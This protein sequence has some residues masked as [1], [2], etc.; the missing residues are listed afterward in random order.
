MPQLKSS[1]DKSHAMGILDYRPWID[2]LQIAISFALAHQLTHQSAPVPYDLA[3]AYVLTFVAINI[4][5]GNYRSYWRYTGLHDAI[6][7][8]LASVAVGVSSIAASIFLDGIN[9]KVAFVATILSILGMV[10]VRV[11]RRLHH[12]KSLKKKSAGKPTLVIGTNSNM[13]SFL[14]LCRRDNGKP[15]HPTGIVA[16]SEHMLGRRLHHV[17]VV[18]TMSDIRDAIIRSGA[19][20]VVAS[21]ANLEAKELQEVMQASHDCGVKLLLR[22]EG[23]TDSVEGI[24][25]VNL[26]DLLPRRHI[27]VDLNGVYKSLNDKI[28][29]VTGG[30]GSIGSELCR[31]IARSNFSKLIVMDHSEFNLFQIGQELA[32][33]FPQRKADIIPVLGDIKSKQ[34]VMQVFEAHRPQVVFHAAAYKHVHLVELNPCS[35]ILN[36]VMGTNNVLK[37]SAKYNVEKFVLISTDKAV[38]PTSIMGATK[39]ICEL[40][41]CHHASV[42]GRSYSAVRF[43]NVLG[44]SG[45]LIPILSEQ[46]RRGGPVTVT[47]EGMTR[48]FMTIPEAVKLVLMASTISI[49]GDV[50]ILKM[51]EAVKIVEVA[52]KL[53]LLSGKKLEDVPVIFTGAKPGEKLYEE[54]Y[55]CG[56]EVQTTHPDIVTLPGGDAGKLFANEFACRQFEKHI[57]EMVTLALANDFDSKNILMEIVNATNREA[58]TPQLEVAV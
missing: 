40:M 38:N 51:G 23:H 11:C 21:R 18:G 33:T 15:F 6:N 9:A 41:V 42:T 39:R 55:L 1:E 16:A 58:R 12:E 54:L 49:P 37:E 30:G 47:D 27:E 29:L 3:A 36:N 53:I 34:I 24:R 44:S 19:K 31:Q 35:A 57:E 17:K 56:N 14:E 10:G 5:I 45:S 43:G 46:I 2:A 52:K 20:V 8:S 26:E 28:V 50:N 25:A 13:L 7:L 32:R 4:L 22:E 48:F